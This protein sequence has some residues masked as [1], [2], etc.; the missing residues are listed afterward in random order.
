MTRQA[1]AR[2]AG[3]TFLVYIAAGVSGMTGLR[4]ALADIVLSLV[5]CCSAFV[6]AVTLYRVT[7]VEHPDIAMFGLACRVAE[8]IV[9][10]AF[11]SV[12]LALPSLPDTDAGHA[13]R[14]FVL[15]AR[16]WN[17]LLSATLFAIG[18]TAFT[19]LLLRGRMIPIAIAWLGVAASLALLVGLPLQLAGILARSL[20]L[21]MWLP[22]LVFEVTAAIWL[23]VKGVAP[24]P[25]AAG[26][27]TA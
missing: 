9:G 25:L 12:Y 26:A 20:A 15:N 13:I 7:C 19:W 4:G 3:V 8:G 1:S 6:L 22:M 10:A 16:N 14:A 11:M 21:L 27:A 2:A 5:M 17:V 24:A 23:I 18:S